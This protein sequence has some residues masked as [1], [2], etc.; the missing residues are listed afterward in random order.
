[1]VSLSLRS[2]AMILTVSVAILSLVNAAWDWLNVRLWSLKSLLRMWSL[3][4][5]HL[6]LH[7]VVKY[8]HDLGN[9]KKITQI[10]QALLLSALFLVCLV[11]FYG[12]L[13]KELKT[14]LSIPR[15]SLQSVSFYFSRTNPFHIF[16][17]KQRQISRFLSWWIWTRNWYLGSWRL[18]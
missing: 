17:E 3:P 16:G 6:P 5:S 14:S 1:M 9:F 7:Q 11:G 13:V 10:L 8:S 15:P 12:L 18:W 2:G 4:L